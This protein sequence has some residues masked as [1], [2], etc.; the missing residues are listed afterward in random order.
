MA[1]EEGERKLSGRVPER[2]RE[3][4]RAW[5]A[6]ETWALTQALRE[7]HTSTEREDPTA[8][9]HTDRGSRQAD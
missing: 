9:M 2:K 1:V 4:G 6:L 5:D 7:S 8:H 3:V